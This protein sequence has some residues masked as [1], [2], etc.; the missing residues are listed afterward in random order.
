MKTDCEQNDDPGRGAVVLAGGVDEA[1]G[2]QQ[3]GE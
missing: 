3:G 2:V 1:H